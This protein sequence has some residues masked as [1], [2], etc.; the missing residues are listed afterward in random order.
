MLPGFPPGVLLE[1]VKVGLDSKDLFLMT[2]SYRSADTFCD[3]IGGGRPEIAVQKGLIAG[4][5]G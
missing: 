3:A 2:T 5:G 1:T 4:K